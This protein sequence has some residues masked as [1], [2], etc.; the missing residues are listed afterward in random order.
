MRDRNTFVKHEP[1]GDAGFVGPETDG[2]NVLFDVWLLSRATTGLLDAALAPTGLSADEF[3]LYSVLKSA[4]SLTPSE[5]ARWMAAPATTVSSSVKRLEARGHLQRGRN[6]DDG[7]SWVLSLTLDGRRAHQA[8]VE[9]FVPVLDAVVAALGPLE[10]PV[11]QALA[12]LRRSIEAV[13]VDDG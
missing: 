8:A 4:D 7:R 12:S 13:R 5:L 11:R 10:P 1:A 6:P 3:G 9:R 2:T